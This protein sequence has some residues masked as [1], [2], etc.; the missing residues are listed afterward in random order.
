MR[1]IA[2]NFPILLL[3]F[4]MKEIHEFNVNGFLTSIIKDPKSP[5]FSIL[6]KDSFEK[7]YSE[8]DCLIWPEVMD[9]MVCSGEVQKHDAVFS[10]SEIIGYLQ[11][12]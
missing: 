6:D 5:Y 12:N 4:S 3:E 1:I 7:V 9:S 10:K 8:N 11:L 2:R